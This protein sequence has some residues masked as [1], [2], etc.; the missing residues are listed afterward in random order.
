MRQNIMRNTWYSKYAQPK[1]DQEATKETN[2]REPGSQKSLQGHGPNNPI[3]SK[4]ISV[5]S[6]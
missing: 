4:V 6:I 2:R 5:G 3:I 1:V